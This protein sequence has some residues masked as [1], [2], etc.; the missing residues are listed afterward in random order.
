MII[1]GIGAAVTMKGMRDQKKAARQARRAQEAANRSKQ[2]QAAVDNR[3]RRAKLIRQMQLAQATAE[4][5]QATQGG[6]NA[7]TTMA[8]GALATAT[9]QG[10]VNL[11]NFEEGGRLGGRLGDAQL[12]LGRAQS[13]MASGKALTSLGGKIMGNAQRIGGMFN[14]LGSFGA[15]SS[16]A[17]SPQAFGASGDNDAG[18]SLPNA[19]QTYP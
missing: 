5:V 9:T 12:Q 7:T 15:A 4:N 16:A 1:V 6:G 14:S 8:T 17:Q 18:Y 10:A 3:A 2:G 19:Y 13:R 11:A